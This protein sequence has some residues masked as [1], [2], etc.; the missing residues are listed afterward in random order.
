M[1]IPL[2]NQA[3]LMTNGPRLVREKRHWDNE[4][5]ERTE[6]RDGATQCPKCGFWWPNIE[7]PDMWDENEVTGNLDAINWWGGV[8]CSDCSLLI[9]EQP[10]GR[11]ECYELPRGR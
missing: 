6:I 7:E 9:V 1:S 11:S 4:G 5:Y 8:V 10:D 3:D 2:C